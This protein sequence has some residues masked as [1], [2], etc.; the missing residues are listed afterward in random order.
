[1]KF[2]K[3]KSTGMQAFSCNGGCANM[4]EDTALYSDPYFCCIRA[5][6]VRMCSVVSCVLLSVWLT[7]SRVNVRIC[8]RCF[9]PR[10]PQRIRTYDHTHA[11]ARSRPFTQARIPKKNALPVPMLRQVFLEARFHCYLHG[12]LH[13]GIPSGSWLEL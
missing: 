13:F 7:D 1:M 9:A 4:K 10:V 8:A 3:K 2:L 6:M 12:F 11:N 5:T